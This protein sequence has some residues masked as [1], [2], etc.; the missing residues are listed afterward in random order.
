MSES[1]IR[2][3]T[4]Y[5][6]DIAGS[7][8]SHSPSILFS[9]III[10]FAVYLAGK[11]SRVVE[12]TSGSRSGDPLLSGFLGGI[13]R[14]IVIT[15]GVILALYTVGL[16]WIA[17]GLVAGAGISAFVVGFAFKDIAENFLAGIILAFSRPYQIGDTIESAGFFGNVLSLDIRNTQIKTFDGKD[18][19]IPNSM[20]LKNP[21]INFTKDGYLRLEFL[22]G[23][24]Y[25]E[26][27][28]KVT[29]LIMDEILKVEGILGGDRKPRIHI[30]TFAASALNLRVYFWVDTF[31]KQ[32]NGQQIRT[33]VMNRVTSRLMSEGVIMP[34]DIR[35][36]KIYNENFPIPVRIESD[37]N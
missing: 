35:E 13:A 19:F 8:L 22:I 33:D 17:G 2:N 26:N 30:D 37:K 12:N 10:L 24:D 5:L 7:I 20:I 27:I 25:N 36:L 18:V 14:W 4:V 29:K 28:D 11:I 16:G 6:Q 32:R 1:L 9:L 34:A 3:F 21:L 15:V 23:I 31:N